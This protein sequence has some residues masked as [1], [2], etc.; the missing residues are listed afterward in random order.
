M[1]HNTTDGPE[2]C[3]LSGNYAYITWLFVTQQD[4]L[5]RTGFAKP[6]AELLIAL[7]LPKTKEAKL[8]RYPALALLEGSLVCILQSLCSRPDWLTPLKGPW[9]VV[10]Q[11]DLG[12][13]TW[14]GAVWQ[15]FN[16][17][18]HASELW[19]PVWI[20]EDPLW[21]VNRACRPLPGMVK[22]NE[23]R[24]MTCCRLIGE[25]SY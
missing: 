22:M 12:D 6:V 1:W 20:W 24:A 25:G 9:R 14:M 13:D 2:Q 4:L 21:R 5:M 23:P 7:Q 17:S 3:E 15:I 10:G 8:V 16:A 11:P 18:F 19:D